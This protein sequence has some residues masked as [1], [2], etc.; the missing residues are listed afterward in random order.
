MGRRFGR[1]EGV[2]WILVRN[3]NILL[4]SRLFVLGVREFVEFV[5]LGRLFCFVFEG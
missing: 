4:F 1:L 5:V 3:T 2:G